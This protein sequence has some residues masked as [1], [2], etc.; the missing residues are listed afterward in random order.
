MIMGEILSILSPGSLLSILS[1][2]GLGANT[3]ADT[4]TVPTEVVLW[5]IAPKNT[6]S[7]C[8]DVT[9]RTYQSPIPHDTVH[10]NCYMKYRR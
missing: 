4:I 3:T 9:T 2:I 7:K 8:L 6:R 5:R 1:Q 10:E